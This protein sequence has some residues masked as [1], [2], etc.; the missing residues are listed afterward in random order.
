MRR[1]GGRLNQTNLLT[2]NLHPS[3]DTLPSSLYRHKRFKSSLFSHLRNKSKNYTFH[4][5]QIWL[6]ES[7]DGWGGEVTTNTPYTYSYAYNPIPSKNSSGTRTHFSQILLVCEEG[8]PARQ[9]LVSFIITT[10][11]NGKNNNQ[12]I[13]KNINIYCLCMSYFIV[14]LL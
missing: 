13:K 5:N 1:E 8:P 6:S 12:Q 10:T 14:F 9:S 3:F 2:F 11:K 4:L 7:Q